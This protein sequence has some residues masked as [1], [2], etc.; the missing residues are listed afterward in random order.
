MPLDSPISKSSPAFGRLRGDYDEGS[1]VRAAE[2][3]ETWT[4]KQAIRLGLRESEI[5]ELIKRGWLPHQ[6]EGTPAGCLSDFESAPGVAAIL[7]GRPTFD[8]Y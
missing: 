7:A 5:L 3:A 4:E 8:P 2:C 6:I 1:R